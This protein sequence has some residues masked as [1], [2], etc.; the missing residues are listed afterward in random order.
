MLRLEHERMER[1][2]MNVQAGRRA[3]PRRELYAGRRRADAKRLQQRSEKK[4]R[5]STIKMLACLAVFLILIGVKFFFPAGA[6]AVSSQISNGLDYKAAFS[7]LGKAIASGENIAEVFK[8]ITLGGFRK[9]SPSPAPS[10]GND[11]AA[12]PTVTPSATPAASDAA[13]DDSPSAAAKDAEAVEA[14][15]PVEVLDEEDLPDESN[16]GESES[17]E[18]SSAGEGSESEAAEG[19]TENDKYMEE[20]LLRLPT[21]ELEEETDESDDEPPEKVSYDYYVIEFDYVTPLKGNITDSFGYRTH[22]I[23]GKKSFHYGV[24]IGGAVGEKVAAFSS[25]TV[26]LKGYNSIYGN[27]LFIRHKDGIITF[28]G[29]CSKILVDE[30]QL[31]RTG[32][33]IAK[34][35]STGLSTGP[36]LHFEIRNGDVIL[37]PLHYISPES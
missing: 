27:Y 28:Y 6:E 20:L 2:V 33:T 22:P 15:S 37:D 4:I 14:I 3:M 32:E 23:T 35:G 34:V 25:G 36:H 21:A 9:E 12:V 10:Q 13:G 31:V 17:G 5:A 16:S 19:G 8:G 7:A 26:E 1:K 24:D 29:H 18:T 30:G 11:A